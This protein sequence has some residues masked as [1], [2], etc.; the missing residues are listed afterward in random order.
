MAVDF[1]KDETLIPVNQNHSRQT[2]SGSDSAF[3]GSWGSSSSSSFLTPSFGSELDSNDADLDDGGG[4]D[5]DFIAQLSRQM[6]DYMLEEKEDSGSEETQSSLDSGF[7]KRNFQETNCNPNQEKTRR[8]YADTVKKS[9][10]GFESKQSFSNDKQIQP[11]IQLYQVENQPRAGGQSGAWGKRGK[12]SEL[13]QHM[14]PHRPEAHMHGINIGVRGAQ[15][16]INGGKGYHSVHGSS[17]AAG[18]GMRAIFLG[19]PGSQNVMNGTGVFLPRS[20]TDAT[21]QGRK[22]P[23]CSTVLVP[24]RVLQ[25][26]EQHFNNMESLSSPNSA[27][28]H[29]SKQE[30][31]DRSQ[32]KEVASLDNQKHKLPQEWTY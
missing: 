16:Y 31:R 12:M 13:T 32:A 21:V 15:E 1:K 18:S 4:D 29:L 17:T 9:I 24:T 25:A 6:A 28:N 26:L 8:S 22:K 2:D 5:D 3:I 7:Q 23:G 27:Q 11:P 20:T 14:T 19:G 10:V 30:K